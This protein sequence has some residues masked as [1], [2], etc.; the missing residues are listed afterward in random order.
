M[1]LKLLTAALASTRTVAFRARQNKR[2]PAPSAPVVDKAGVTFAGKVDLLYTF[3]APAVSKPPMQHPGTRTGCFPGKRVYA[4]EKKTGIF[5]W[6]QVDLVARVAGLA[7]YSHA[8]MDSLEFEVGE[9]KQI[10]HACSKKSTSGPP[11][12]PK[13]A[14][15]SRRNYARRSA[16]I[17]ELGKALADF[18][19]LVSYEQDEHVAAAQVG[20]YGW[21][22]VHT[23][24]HPGNIVGGPQVA[25]LIQHPESLECVLTFQG[26]DSV[27][28]LLADV[29][30]FGV[31]FC[32]VAG[33]VHKGFRDQM[34][35]IVMSDIFQ[36]N[37]RPFL[38]S[39]HTVTVLGHSLGGAMA[40]LFTG[41]MATAP[42]PGTPGWETDFKHLHWNQTVVSKLPYINAMP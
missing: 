12:R 38:P 17:E 34:R 37:I 19:G 7:G 3:G 15:H 23:A 6:N 33:K 5:G 18:A 14:L 39:C 4:S 1:L 13:F 24:F 8:Y 42:Q 20:S 29:Y 9:N 30:A 35:K 16:E 10:I 11:G 41:C 26:T 36:I 21:G 22:L 31:D 32:G 2:V 27:Q 28:D 40:E 25:H